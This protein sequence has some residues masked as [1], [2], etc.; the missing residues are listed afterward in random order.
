[1]VDTNG[2]PGAKAGAPI[3]NDTDIT[4]VNVMA[5]IAIADLLH[6]TFG[7]AGRDKMLVD[8]NRMVVITNDGST[9]LG[10]IDIEMDVV[11]AARLL[12]EL[13][14]R[15]GD[16]YQDGTKFTVIVS[17]E[18]LRQSEP[19]L[20]QGVHPTN[21]VGGYRQAAARVT[22]TIEKLSWPIDESDD[23]DLEDV[24]RVALTG[25]GPPAAARALPNLVVAAVRAVAAGESETIDLDY[26][27]TE[28]AVGGV[29]NDSILMQGLILNVPDPALPSM[30][31]SVS[32]ARVLCLG[33]EFSVT[34]EDS[35]SE[36]MVD[37]TATLERFVAFERDRSARQVDLL[38]D[39]GVNVVF[40]EKDIDQQIR[41]RLDNRDILAIKRV[42]RDDIERLARAT[43]ASIVTNV[44]EVEA[45]DIGRADLVEQRVFSGE[46][47]LVIEGCENPQSVTLLVRGGTEHSLDEVERA[48]RNSLTV[49]R[50]TLLDGRV[51]PGGGAPE[52]EAALALRRRADGVDGRERLAMR[53]FADALESIPRILAEN[54][55][56]D[57]IDCLVDLRARH[58]AGHRHAGVIPEHGVI[59]DVVEEG[60]VEPLYLK[61]Q[62]IEAAT[63][64]AVQ[65]LRVDDVISA[66][67]LSDG[68]V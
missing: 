34:R 11:P 2:Q 3:N 56:F 53:V 19:L 54:A 41:R 61:T 16:Q 55:G 47:R 68:F 31:R 27:T 45:N 30:P 24:A 12:T 7:P 36:V 1:M 46:D 15:H 44:T 65:V 52:I 9:I 39:F 40:C 43:G 33:A 35:V 29:V 14:H 48:V 37:D 64:V 22:E 51:L 26:V 8:A 38:A 57:P 17:G 10:E 32:D 4:N 25:R 67:D 20:E 18:L 6:P 66:T 59:D 58:Q 60:V 5:G 50:A 49:V 28:K 63:D 13:S 42:T 23:A 21:I 62:S